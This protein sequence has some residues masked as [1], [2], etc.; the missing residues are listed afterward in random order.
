MLGKLRESSCEAVRSAAENL[1][2]W[3]YI[4]GPSI[5]CCR[6]GEYGSANRRLWDGRL[7]IVVGGGVSRAWSRG[8]VEESARL[9]GGLLAMSTM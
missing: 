9:G 3:V 6:F 4:C 1:K 5:S 8:N 2:V 7:F